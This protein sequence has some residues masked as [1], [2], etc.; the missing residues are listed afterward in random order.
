MDDD[1]FLINDIEKEYKKLSSETKKKYPKLKELV[2]FSLKTIEKIKSSVISPNINT[3]IT[4]VKKQFESELQLSMNIIIK[5]IMIISENKY[6]KFNLSCVLILKKLITYNYITE[7]EYNDIIKI[8]KE[9]Y[10]NS[11]E[12]TQLKILETLQS[13]ISINVSKISEETL[14]NIMIIFC[15]IFCFKNIETKNALQ[16]IL[17]T[18]M[19]KIFDYCDNDIIIG[20][21]KN[22]ILLVDGMKPDWVSIPTVSVKCLGLELITTIIET[23]PDKLKG[24]NYKGIFYDI[25]I[26]L[27]RIYSVNIEQQIMGIKSCRLILVIINKMDILYDMIELPLKFL[28]KNNQIVWQKILGLEIFSELFKNQNFLF[29]LYKQSKSLYEKM[30]INFS[31]ITYQTLKL[32]KKGSNGNTN[33]AG[34]IVNGMNIPLLRKQSDPI[35]KIPN[36][37]Y[38]SNNLIIFDEHIVITQNINYIY[39]LINECFVNIRNSFVGLLEANN[40]DVNVHTLDKK[41]KELKELKNTKENIKMNQTQKDLRE[42][43]CTQFVNLKGSLIGMFINFN[44]LTKSQTFISIMQTFIYIFSSFDLI[45]FRDELLNDLCKLAIPNNLENI[46]EVK[47]KNILIIR[48]IFNLIHCINL[49]DYSSWLILIETIQNLYYILIKSSS[50]LY[51]YKS[52]FNINIILND[53]IENIKKYS[54]STDITEI[55]KMLERKESIEKNNSSQPS[56][57]DL[58]LGNK[59]H[60]KNKSVLMI[61]N[62]NINLSTK[63]KEKEK[64]S[65][66]QK[67]N[68]EIL[69]NAVNTLFI[70]S[71]TYDDNTIQ[72]IIKA[73]YD[74]TKKLFEN[75]I[76]EKLETKKLMKENNTTPNE[77]NTENN[78][79]K[80]ISIS[81]NNPEYNKKDSNNINTS[82][83]LNNANPNVNN[84]NQ[85]QSNNNAYNGRFPQLNGVLS[86]AQ[87]KIMS[88]INYV[89]GIGNYNN[90]NNQKAND[91]TNTNINTNITSNNNTNTNNAFIQNEKLLANLAYINFNLI[92]LL[93]L[94]IININRVHLFWDTIIETVNLLCSNSMNNRFSNILSKFTIEILTQIIIT[95]ILQYKSQ[96]INNNFFSEKEIQITTFKPIYSFLNRHHNISFVLEPL[97]KILEKCSIKLNG[98]GWNSFINILNNILSNGKV[99]SQQ[100]ESVFKIVEQIFNEYAIYL[101]IFN[102]EPILNVLEI[103]SVSKDNNNICYS[104]ISYFW[105]CANICE[106]YQKEKRKISPNEM[107]LFQGKIKYNTDEEKL[108]FLSNIWKDIFFKLININNDERFEI[109]KSGINVFSQIYVAKLKS[110]NSLIDKNKKIKISA[111]II[112][113]LFYEIMNKNI[114][115]YLNNQ[116]KFEDTIVLTLQSIGKIIKCFFEENKDEICYEENNKIFSIFINKCLDLMKKNSPLVSSNILKCIVDLEFFDEKLFLDNLKSNWEVFNEIGKF[117]SDENLFIKN[118]SKTVDGEKLIEIIVETL[119][120]IFTKLIGIKNIDNSTLNNETEKLIKFIPKIF[121][122]LNYTE[123]NFIKANPKVLINTENYLF[124]LIELLGQKLEKNEIIILILNYLIS[125][126]NFEL[127]NPHSEILC[128]RSLESIEIIFNNNEFIHTISNEEIA[129]IILNII[130]AVITILKKRNENEVLEHIIKYNKKDNKYIFNF[131]IDKILY[132]IFDT[133]FLDIK[134]KIIIDKL[135]ILFNELFNNNENKN[136]FNALK[137]QNINEFIKINEDIEISIINFILNNLYLKS[138]F[139]TEELHNKILSL[140]SYDDSSKISFDNLA[141]KSL[142]EI[143]KLKP[144]EEIK[145]QFDE[146]IKIKK[147]E[148][149]LNNMNIFIEKYLEIRIKIA[150]KCI[151]KLIKKSIGEMKNYLEKIKNNKKLIYEDKKIK[152]ILLN[153]KELNYIQNEDDEKMYQNHIMKECLKSNKGH[154]FILHLI[155]TEFIQVAN[156]SEIINIIKDIFKVISDELGIKNDE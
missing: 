35:F 64:L 38:L 150:K 51:E 24:D 93:C 65:E 132:N 71:N 46:F 107:E 43:I 86:A 80:H 140:I 58:N 125:F 61:S 100:C 148:N 110:M 32:K 42:M 19:K 147:D 28:E 67:E 141:I 62:N 9:M 77:K 1:L 121:N 128:K 4:Q 133:I 70:E 82:N 76:K 131:I 7:S 50:Y 137:E 109:R 12:D 117:I 3:N 31:D 17:G 90:A 92:K 89:L 120:N 36:K 66:E 145:N 14:N 144:K 97:Q 151:P 130:N 134:D 88:N 13:L 60:R 10:D 2:D 95:I 138:F 91:T 126:I 116:E 101:N 102:I 81:S 8:L 112:Y 119:R 114:K 45:S 129:K 75:Y 84:N 27:K 153:L 29:G 63:E 53:L 11:N 20:L 104:S 136:N 57:P 113:E 72:T 23:F 73:L 30:L 118:Y 106:D 127:E 149:N 41:K 123:Y 155:F 5:P 135:I 37:K 33:E 21:M 40:I 54:Y 34:T 22:L 49:L 25:K 55:E 108:D 78:N 52:I 39:K 152:Y 83:P 122:A 26:L 59:E 142:F 103:F 98:L 79:N 139:L 96:E 44:D 105:Q 48:A 16:L 18:F 111:E 156:N 85:P 6:S 115:N 15:R 146:I 87:T 74:N 69:S 94:T 99:D 47:D 68:I 154:L 56:L 124:E 143:C